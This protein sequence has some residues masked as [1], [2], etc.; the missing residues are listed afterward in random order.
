MKFKVYGPQMLHGTGPSKNTLSIDVTETTVIDPHEVDG[1]IVEGEQAVVEI[2]RDRNPDDDDMEISICDG[3][4]WQYGEEA[5][6][7]NVRLLVD[8]LRAE[9]FVVKRFV[10]Y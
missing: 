8:V 2:C 9:G 5:W 1:V 10:N 3:I 4:E 6:G 7:D